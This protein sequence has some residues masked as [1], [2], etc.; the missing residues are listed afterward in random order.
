[1]ENVSKEKLRCTIQLV[2][3]DADI[4][5]ITMK[6]VRNTLSTLLACDMDHRKHEINDIVRSE[7][8]LRDSTTMNTADN[9]KNNYEQNGTSTDSIPDEINHLSHPQSH[10]FSSDVTFEDIRKLQAKFANERNWNRYH[11][12]RNLLLALVGEVGELAELFQWKNEVLE[13]LPDWTSTERQNVSDEL[14]V[15]DNYCV[16]NTLTTCASKTLKDFQSPYTSTIIQRLID[17]GGI[18][19]GKTNMDEFSM[20]TASWGYMGPVVNPW[21]LKTTEKHIAGGSSGGSAAAVAA[22]LVPISIGSDTGG[23]VRAPAA[24]CGCYGFKASYGLLSR[25]GLISLVNSFDSPGI[26]SRTI[27]DIVLTMNAMAGP[28]EEDA[29]LLQK[30]FEHIELSGQNEEKKKIV[31]GLPEEYDIESLSDEYRSCW[32][33]VIDQLTSLGYEIKR[34]NLPYTKY[35]IACYTVLASCEITSNMARFDGIKYGYRTKNVEK[36][37]TYE[38]ILTKT[39]NESLGE[40][41][42]GR[43]LAGNYFLREEN[44]DSYF[45]QSQKVRRAIVHDYSTLFSTGNIDCLLAPV[46]SDDPPTFEEYQNTNEI[47]TSDDLLTVGVNLAGLPALS[48][49]VKL[50]KKG[51]PISLQLIGPFMKDKQLLQLA[52][53]ICSIFQF[54]FLDLTKDD[55]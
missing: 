53:K 39:R 40:R 9:R 14:I 12:P 20:G 7:I 36:G 41:V 45:V 54:P 25:Y 26:F 44:Y 8:L 47:F 55:S 50:S 49:P 21:S 51:F 43:I 30:P 13:G 29:T 15:K 23:S 10:H 5:I 16:S 2:L 31:I 35:S 3:K 4:S 11:T 32:F 37:A 34:C 46:V 19:I 27:S 48:F 42:R 24:R 18:V 33:E 1:M 28:D 22:N 38:Q 17:Q 6:D 52:N